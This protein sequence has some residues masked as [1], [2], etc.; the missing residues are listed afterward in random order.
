MNDP[1]YTPQIFWRIA[2]SLGGLVHWFDLKGG[3]EPRDTGIFY[4][5]SLWTVAPTNFICLCLCP[6][7]TA[8][9]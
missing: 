1:P 9:I 7:F 4:H 8:Y 2:I 6:A 3:V 5:P